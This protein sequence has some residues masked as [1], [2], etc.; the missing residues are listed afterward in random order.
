M[1]SGECD[2]MAASLAIFSHKFGFESRHSHLLLGILKLLKDNIL[3]IDYV[4]KFTS[5]FNV[6]RGVCCNGRNLVL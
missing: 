5:F 3:Y 2:G 1:S 4:I 6:L